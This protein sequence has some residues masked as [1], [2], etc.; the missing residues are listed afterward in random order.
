MRD[1]SLK[2]QDLHSTVQEAIQEPGPA[3][4]QGEAGPTGAPGEQGP[5]GPKGEQGPAGPKGEQGPAGPKGDTGPAGAPGEQ[6]PAGQPGAPG[7][8]GPAGVSGYQTVESPRVTF[9]TS[10]D[11]YTYF[12]SVSATCPGS[13]RPL[14]GGYDIQGRIGDVTV[15]SMKPTGSAYTVSAVN[16]GN[17][18]NNSIS[19]WAICASV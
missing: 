10:S 4:P 1:G 16:A 15:V 3:G 12:R 2:T 8:A 9:G 18:V 17:G 19:V 7:P 5:A 14:G 13:T 6:G 11:P